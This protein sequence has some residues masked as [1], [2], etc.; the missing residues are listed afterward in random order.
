MKLVG[1]LLLLPFFLHSENKDSLANLHYKVRFSLQGKCM[2]TQFYYHTTNDQIEQGKNYA[3][4]YYSTF[5]GKINSDYTFNPEFKIDFELPIWLKISCG[6]NLNITKFNTQSD[7]IY[8]SEYNIYDPASTPSN[9]IVIGVNKSSYSV[10]YNKDEMEISNFGT[11]VGLGI[12][13][14]YKRFVFDVDYCFSLNRTMNAFAITRIYDNNNILE[15]TEGY[16]FMNNYLQANDW[17][18]FTHNFSTS[19][20]YRFYKNISLKAG[21]H[22]SNYDRDIEDNTYQHYSTFKKIK[23]HSLFAGIAFS[24]FNP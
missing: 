3:E 13:K 7:R 14:Q 20:S 21:L 24:F 1:W 10:G 2:A 9:P 17:I 16:N 11:F 4:G 22:Y 15:K 19:L 5:K 12:S 6:F 18:M 8:Y 23:S